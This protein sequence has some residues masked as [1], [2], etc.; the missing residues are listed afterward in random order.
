MR[1]L[2]SVSRPV[3]ETTREHDVSGNGCFRL[4]VRVE[5]PTLL[6]PLGP[7]HEVGIIQFPKRCFL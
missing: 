3:F 2:D 5:R 4:H 7:S 1:L 6:G